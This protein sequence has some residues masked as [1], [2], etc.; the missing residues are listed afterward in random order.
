MDTSLSVYDSGINTEALTDTALTDTALTDTP[1]VVAATPLDLQ[2]ITI[3][4]REYHW[5]KLLSH[6]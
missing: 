2:T 5:P 3:T 4:R 1:A 6:P